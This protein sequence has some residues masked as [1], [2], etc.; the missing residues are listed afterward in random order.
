MHPFSNGYETYSYFKILSFL[1]KYIYWSYCRSI[2]SESHA[3]IYVGFDKQIYF[4]D[5]YTQKDFCFFLVI[6]FHVYKLT[7]KISLSIKKTLV[8]EKPENC[9][10]WNMKLSGLKLLKVLHSELW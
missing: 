1:A 5:F 2:K 9:R 6:G 3:N 4:W 10:E 7:T 8:R